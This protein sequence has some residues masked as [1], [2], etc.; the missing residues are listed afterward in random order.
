MQASAFGIR[1]NRTYKT[2][3]QVDC[4]GAI[5]AIFDR[6]TILPAGATVS[7]IGNLTRTLADGGVEPVVQ[8]ETSSQHYE[9]TIQPGKI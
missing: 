1:T 5:S 2:S 9:P 7:D 3:Y 8:Y 4:S 6:V